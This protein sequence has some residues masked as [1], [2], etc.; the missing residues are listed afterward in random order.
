MPGS[1]SKVSNF[2]PLPGSKSAGTE[3]LIPVRMETR[4]KKSRRGSLPG[5]RPSQPPQPAP[6]TDL[7]CAPA[8]EGVVA[9]AH[10]GSSVPRVALRG[11]T[12]TREPPLPPAR[13]QWRAGRVCSAGSFPARASA[14]PPALPLPPPALR[15][16][17]RACGPGKGAVYTLR[18][19]PA[20]VR[21]RGA[22]Q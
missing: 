14:T 17:A 22:W 8:A 3:R 15:G 21:S 6:Q 7:D 9:P 19:R 13:A 12:V 2:C 20:I 11:A 5:Q 10:H 4:T 18:S 1:V 16:P